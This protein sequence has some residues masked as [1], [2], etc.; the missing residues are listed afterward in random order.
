MIIAKIIIDGIEKEIE[1]ESDEFFSFAVKE[2]KLINLDNVAILGVK[3]WLNKYLQH[4]QEKRGD[5]YL[6][7][8]YEGIINNKNVVVEFVDFDNNQNNLTIGF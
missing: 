3:N 1:M 4:K 7:D 6:Y 5:G 2:L 8:V